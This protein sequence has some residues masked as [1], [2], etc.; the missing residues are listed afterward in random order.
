MNKIISN[1]KAMGFSLIVTIIVVLALFVLISMIIFPNFQ[2]LFGITDRTLGLGKCDLT[3]LKI[4][5]YTTPLNEYKAKK[6]EF[7]QNDAKIS[8]LKKTCEDF[9]LCFSDEYTKYKDLC[10][11][12]G[13]GGKK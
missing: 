3:G 10:L 6:A 12:L 11:S 1:K 4:S 7:D 8:E 9:D 2:E 5:D 13:N